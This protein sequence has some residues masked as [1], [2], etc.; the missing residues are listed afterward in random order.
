MGVACDIVRARHLK[1]L[2]EITKPPTVLYATDWLSGGA[3]AEA[4]SIALEDVQ[5][6]MEVGFGLSSE[7]AATR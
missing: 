4:V 2:A 3:P 1:R 7:I 5:A 6:L